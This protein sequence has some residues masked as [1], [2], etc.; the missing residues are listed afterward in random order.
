MEIDA[1]SGTFQAFEM[2]GHQLLQKE[3]YASDDVKAK[4]D[5]LAEARQNL[6][7]SVDGFCK[8]LLCLNLNK[9]SCGVLAV[10]CWHFK[11]NVF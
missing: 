7:K 5:E 8:V 2:F 10:W 1:R 11:E 3:H 6:E 4:L 9:L